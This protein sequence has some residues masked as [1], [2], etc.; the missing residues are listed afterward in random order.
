MFHVHQSQPFWPLIIYR[1]S[2]STL[3]AYLNVDP[4]KYR[5]FVFC[6][7]RGVCKIRG[8]F[9]HFIVNN[10]Y[11]VSSIFVLNAYG[12]QLFSIIPNKKM[13]PAHFN[14]C[15]KSE[16]SIERYRIAETLDL[17]TEFLARIV[18]ANKALYL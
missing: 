8:I 15:G 3:F 2:I 18:S 12:E 14:K 16:S 5:R 1:I 7:E 13:L 4:K 6:F 9:L 10:L 11:T 17:R